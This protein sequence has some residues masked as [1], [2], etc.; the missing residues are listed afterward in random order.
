VEIGY[1]TEG[2]EKVGIEDKQ[3]IPCLSLYN[4][5]VRDNGNRKLPIFYF[6]LH[7]KLKTAKAEISDKN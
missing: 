5:I 6:I 1:F 3:I 2:N 7:F 4:L